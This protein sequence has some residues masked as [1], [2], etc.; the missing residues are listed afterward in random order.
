M[1]INTDVFL[2]FTVLPLLP[3][4]TSGAGSVSVTGWMANGTCAGGASAAKEAR[5]DEV[6]GGM[7][8]DDLLLGMMAMDPRGEGRVTND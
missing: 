6:G 8:N 3:L 1:A 5:V 2:S 4:P 7:L